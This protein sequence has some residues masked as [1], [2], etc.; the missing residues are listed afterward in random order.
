MLSRD[1]GAPGRKLR[2]E[3]WSRGGDQKNGF[4]AGDQSVTLC[5]PPTFASILV[6]LSL[7]KNFE[8]CPGISPFVVIMSALQFKIRVGLRKFLPVHR[9]WCNNSGPR[10]ALANS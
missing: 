8:T 9:V 7:Q 10:I 4:L 6:H 2:T 1:G 5:N 3:V